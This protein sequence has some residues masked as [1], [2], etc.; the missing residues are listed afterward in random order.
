MW[1]KVKTVEKV[2]HEERK[3]EKKKRKSKEQNPGDGK[4]NQSPLPT[5]RLLSSLRAMATVD[6]AVPRFHC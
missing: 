4:T 1:V 3:K 6:R 5:R 2:R